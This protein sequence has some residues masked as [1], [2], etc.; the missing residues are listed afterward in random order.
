MVG[1]HEL[2]GGRK[3]AVSFLN[4]CGVATRGFRRV[5][6]PARRFDLVAPADAVKPN[7]LFCASSSM[8]LH[9]LKPQFTL[10]PSISQ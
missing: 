8:R 9:S 10:R 5:S 4:L 2:R 1:K 6:A 3:G 7:S